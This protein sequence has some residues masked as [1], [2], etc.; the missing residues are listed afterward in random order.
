[1]HGRH[2][3]EGRARRGA[4]RIHLARLAGALV[5]SAAVASAAAAGP[6]TPEAVRLDAVWRASMAAG[7]EAADLGR[8]E[9]AARAFRRAVTRARAGLPDDA[10]GFSLYRLGDLFR[11]RPDLSRGESAV[12]L[13]EEA[14]V[15]LARAYGAGHPVLLPVWARIAVLRFRAGE[16][17][18]AAAA[19]AAA[20][21]I[22]VRCFPER[23]FLRE[24]FGTT[25][26]ASLV[27]PLEVLR[28]LEAEAGPD[29][30]APQGVLARD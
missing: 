18:R 16:H 4:S 9:A 15:H 11:G 7:L 29:E 24:R 13:L 2:P 19:R 10:L 23:H 3:Q 14:R 25:R 30:I 8:P 26:A 28:L 6:A 1:M 21:A 17:E 22:A 27:H 12:E 5:A 20:D